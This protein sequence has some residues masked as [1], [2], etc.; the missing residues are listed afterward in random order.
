MSSSNGVNYFVGKE[1]LARDGIAALETPPCSCHVASYEKL[2]STPY[3]NKSATTSVRKDLK[4]LVKVSEKE[5]ERV[6]EL[7][8]K[9]REDLERNQREVEQ[10]DANDQDNEECQ[11]NNQEQVAAR[12]PRIILRV[13]NSTLARPGSLQAGPSA[14]PRPTLAGPSPSARRPNIVLRV[15]NSTLE[16][17]RA[18]QAGPSDSGLSP[19]IRLFNKNSTLSPPRAP[20]AGQTS[21]ASPAPAEQ[22]KSKKRKN[23]GLFDMESIAKRPHLGY[24]APFVKNVAAKP[25]RADNFDYKT[26]PSSFVPKSQRTIMPE[27][28]FK[29][30]ATRRVTSKGAKLHAPEGDN[31]ARDRGLKRN[32]PTCGPVSSAKKNERRSDLEAIISRKKHEA[33]YE[34]VKD[35]L[36][37]F[38]RR[39]GC[40]ERAP[41]VYLDMKAREEEKAKAKAKVKGEIE[42]KRKA[43]ERAFNK[44]QAFQ[45]ENRAHEAHLTEQRM[46]P[47]KDAFDAQLDFQRQNTIHENDLDQVEADYRQKLAVVSH[48]RECGASG[49]AYDAVISDLEEALT[50]RMEFTTWYKHWKKERLAEIDDLQQEAKSGNDG[51]EVAKLNKKESADSSCAKYKVAFQCAILAKKAVDLK[52]ELTGMAKEIETINEKIGSDDNSYRLSARPPHMQKLKDGI[53]RNKRRILDNPTP[54]RVPRQPIGPSRLRYELGACL[55]KKEADEAAEAAEEAAWEEQEIRRMENLMARKRRIRAELEQKR[56]EDAEKQVK[57]YLSTGITPYL[58]DRLEVLYFKSALA[59]YRK[60][61]KEEKKQSEDASQTDGEEMEGVENGEE[62]E[63]AEVEKDEG[64]KRE[65]D[66]SVRHILELLKSVRTKDDVGSLEKRDEMEGLE[67]DQE[68]EII[69]IEDEGEDEMQGVQLHY[70]ATIKIEDRA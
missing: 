48:E 27:I 9:R 13:P 11:Q 4:E 55:A 40:E 10:N 66:Q 21:S 37:A 42:R 20:Q 63:K 23:E 54:Q 69:V 68:H 3:K 52:E 25:F 26:P 32:L 56:L 6:Q 7:L 44:K 62:H 28:P 22:Q 38:S 2:L 59:E 30:A 50:K 53:G 45:S 47:A 1:K 57:E 17:P 70:S 41:Q 18:P 34:P 14:A 31:F 64:E 36:K 43:A 39:Y 15:P 35:E 51:A 46:E 58:M 29:R 65:Q 60:R 67:S 19:K 61:E 24:C 8:K 33:M 12:H 16:R 49:A 5:V